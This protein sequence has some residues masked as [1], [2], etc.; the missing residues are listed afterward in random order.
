MLSFIDLE[1]RGQRNKERFIS[2]PKNEDEWFGL[3]NPE[4]PDDFQG[5]VFKGKI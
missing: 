3:Q 2:G 4:L 5:E 1:G